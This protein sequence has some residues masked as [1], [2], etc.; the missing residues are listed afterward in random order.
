M[1]QKHSCLNGN[2]SSQLGEP[3]ASGSSDKQRIPISPI[4]D[5]EDL[6]HHGVTL[7]RF[8]VENSNVNPHLQELESVILSV[9]TSK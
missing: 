9:Q 5:D 1:H 2:L 7:T 6:C 3:A 4:F 8:M